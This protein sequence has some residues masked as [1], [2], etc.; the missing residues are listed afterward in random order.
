MTKTVVG[1]PMLYLPVETEVL[2]CS[3]VHV[4]DLDLTPGF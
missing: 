2:V 4:I 1:P 3:F